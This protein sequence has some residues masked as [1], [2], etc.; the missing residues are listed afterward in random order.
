MAWQ[1]RGIDPPPIVKKATADYRRSEDVLQDFIDE[2]CFLDPAHEIGASELYTAFA[3][4]WSEN[5]SKRVPS[6][7]KFGKWMTRRFKREKI[8]TYRYY[9]IGLLGKQFEG[10]S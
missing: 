1:Q 7:K 2:V 6:Q 5:M 9:G 8:G 10:G 4:W 3:E